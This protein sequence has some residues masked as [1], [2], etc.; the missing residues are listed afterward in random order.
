LGCLCIGFIAHAGEI[1]FSS[2]PMIT[3]AKGKT[4]IT[5]TASAV[6]DGE[7]AILNAKG[8]VVRH[9]AAGMIGATNAAAPFKAGLTQSVEWDGCDDAGKKAGGGPFSVRVGLGMQ[10]GLNRTIGGSPY[11]FGRING[12][13][14]DKE[15]LLY[16]F[17]IG[18][19]KADG[20]QTLQ[21]HA[22]DGKYIKTIMPAS[23]SLP[24]EK[25][26]AYGAIDMGDGTWG[27]NNFG[28]G[29]FPQF[30]PGIGGPKKFGQT[31]LMPTVVKGA[32]LLSDGASFRVGGKSQALF[33]RAE[34]GMPPDGRA[35]RRNIWS[36]EYRGSWNSIPNTGKAGTQCAVSPDGKTLYA[37]GPYSLEKTVDELKKH[38]KKW[39]TL[40]P[41]GGLYKINLDSKGST[42]LFTTL[43]A[44]ISLMA[45]GAD[46]TIYIVDK[47]KGRILALDPSG[48]QV[49]EVPIK[50]VSA[51]V[52]HP[53]TSEI[54]AIVSRGKRKAVQ[55]TLVKLSSAKSGGKELARL[56]VG[57]AGY[58]ALAASGERTTVW[59][60]GSSTFFK[61]SKLLR[62]ADTGTAL[63][64]E[65]DIAK[66]A[67]GALPNAVDRAALD[68]KRGELYVNNCFST[69]YRC[70]LKSGVIS[71]NTLLGTDVAVGAD[72]YLYVMGGVTGK[73]FTELSMHG[74][75]RITREGKPAP[76]K[77]VNTHAFPKGNYARHGAGYSSKGICPALNGKTYVMDM[78]GWN[79]YWVTAY[80]S[81]GK[82][83]GGPRAKG[84]NKTRPDGALV[85]NIPNACGGLKVDRAGNIYVAVIG[86]TKGF[87]YPGNMKKKSTTCRAT[88]GSVVK[89]PPT[90]GTFWTAKEAK[91]SKT[92]HPT[93]KGVKLFEGAWMGGSLEVFAAG[94]LQAFSGT[95]PTT[96]LGSCACRTPRFEVDPYGRLYLPDVVS[97]R[98]RVY[99]AAGNPIRTIGSYGNFD[100]QG[101]GSLV[102]KPEIAFGAPLSVAWDDR[103][104]YVSD[105][106]NRRIVDV[107][108]SYATEEV[109]TIK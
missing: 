41:R 43:D 36:K 92:P 23:A 55:F 104:L 102:P 57:G 72:G 77:A 62:I 61:P 87:K 52:V 24:Y 8:K 4:R 1:T 48:K 103:A 66:R 27:F 75:K 68:R 89:F 93:G 46:G 99:D 86:V 80:S 16:V 11:A 20:I 18:C 107:K 82:F 26:Q 94:A 108:L 30:Y 14:T 28:G 44:E 85:D 35:Y 15:G 32:L 40:M 73:P 49:G 21:V 98:V 70:D 34:D 31:I 109:V 58:V 101:E 105:M 83:L 12:I 17:H 29:R 81:E 22:P 65:E 88:M 9:L 90:G 2:K 59:C 37:G 25:V 38:K 47:S 13:A 33:I 64:I 45:T 39:K 69:I 74:W 84:K 7:V 60:A 54:Y 78:Y 97:F 3:K 10:A 106:V 63:T 95:S 67:G 71:T 6:T 96:V 5:F 91:K 56:E 53:A 42:T 19:Y 100:S 51:M 79:K 50:N 76:F